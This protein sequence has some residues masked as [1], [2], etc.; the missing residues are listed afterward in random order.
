[1]NWF[2]QA[3]GSTWVF[4]MAPALLWNQINARNINGN[5]ADNAKLTKESFGVVHSSKNES[6]VVRRLLFLHQNDANSAVNVV[7]N[8]ADEGA[9]N[10]MGKGNGEIM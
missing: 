2:N 9:N 10:V 1:M 7:G 8:G 4:L 5:S 3:Q 6:T